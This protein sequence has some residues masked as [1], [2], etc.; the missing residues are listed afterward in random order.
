M[1]GLN[2]NVCDIMCVK[3]G[4]FIVFLNEG[5]NFFLLFK[6]IYPKIFPASGC[7]TLIIMQIYLLKNNT[8]LKYPYCK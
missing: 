8:L 3:N 2:C 1:S 6:K 5:C 4:L 7:Q